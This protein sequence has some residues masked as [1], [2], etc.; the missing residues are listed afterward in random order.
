[1]TSIAIVILNWNGTSD[2]LACLAS[3]SSANSRDL[4]IIVIHNRSDVD[5]TAEIKSTYP[6][7]TVIC[8][9][10]KVG[11]AAALGATLRALYHLIR[12]PENNFR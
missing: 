11:F 2:T 1:M 3:I 5:P 10:R 4:D 6:S 8:L 12:K 7:A 9:K